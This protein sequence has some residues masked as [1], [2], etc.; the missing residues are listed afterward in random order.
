MK[1]HITIQNQRSSKATK[2]MADFHSQVK[3]S[4][5][6][7]SSK[8][9]D[10]MLDVSCGKAGDLHHWMQTKLER[11]IGVDINRDNLE[12]VRNGACNRILLNKTKE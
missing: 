7:D 5:I 8:G 6:L 11:I 1:R 4:I 9:K 12:N 2:L 3:K 10:V